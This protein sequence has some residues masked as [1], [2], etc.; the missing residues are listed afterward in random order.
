MERQINR[1]SNIK[2]AHLFNIIK[3]HSYSISERYNWISARTYS[4]IPLNNLFR[5]H[6]N[7]IIPRTNSIEEHN[8]L[9]I[10]IALIISIKAHSY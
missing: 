8:K 5:P 3:A 7:S 4:I 1:N 6:T 2:C 10:F 9:N